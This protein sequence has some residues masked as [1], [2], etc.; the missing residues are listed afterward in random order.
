VA[1][2]ALGHMFSLTR[3]IG[4]SNV[5]IREGK[6]NKKKYEGIELCG[7]TLGIVGFGRIGQELAKKTYA[8]GMRIFYNDVLGLNRE[9]PEYTFVP[10]DE[11]LAESD[12]ISLHV[13]GYKEQSPYD[14]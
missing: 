8:L 10:L 13:P 6:W 14:W 12:F 4:I 11:L 2:L 3:F 1:E 7:K 5:T 9:F